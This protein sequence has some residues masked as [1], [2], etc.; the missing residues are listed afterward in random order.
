MKKTISMLLLSAILF[1]SLILPVYAS[2][3]EIIGDNDIYNEADGEMTDVGSIELDAKSAILMDAETGTILFSKNPNA[4]L[5]PASVTKIMTLLLAAEAIQDGRIKLEQNVRVSEQAASMGGS[6]IFLKEGEEFTVEE[7]LKSTVI[8]SAND[9]ATALAELI[10]GSESAFVDKMNKRASEL[11]MKNTHF[12]NATGLDDTTTNHLTS[13]YD[14]ALM[15]R[16][17][18][19]HD[20]I[21]KYSN[22]WQDTIRNGEFTLTN[23]NRL[24]RYYQG[25]TGLKTGSTDK[26]GY[27]ISATAKRDGMHLIAVIMGSSTRDKRNADARALL[28]YGF[29]NY[30]VYNDPECDLELIP[31]KRGSIS[32]TTAYTKPF[33][34]L[35]DKSKAKDIEKIYSIPEFLNAPFGKD[36]VIGEIQYMLGDTVIG[37]TDIY[38]REESE[39]L[40]FS[41][42]IFMI[43]YTVMCGK[44]A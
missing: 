30:T 33:S 44:T 22:I 35:I 15:S 10:C 14:I 43:F 20:C 18:I 38:T 29:A 36:D 39:E 6:Q 21:L 23:T 42:V 13:A 9:A 4:A 31:V 41:D 25:C 27:C 1:C 11:G 8:A 40:S 7:L 12:E 16:E 2:D 34:I 19:K 28:D 3:D 5:P 37:K 24:V 32:A 26:A 17:L